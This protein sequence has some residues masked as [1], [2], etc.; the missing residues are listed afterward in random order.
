[1]IP[2]ELED[3]RCK[4]SWKIYIFFKTQIYN[5]FNVLL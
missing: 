4:I 5:A 1:M 2:W 3:T